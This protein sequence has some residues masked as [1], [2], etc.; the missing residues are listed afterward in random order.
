MRSSR[1]IPRASRRSVL[2]ARAESAALTCRVSNSIKACLAQTVLEPLRQG[3]G[4]QAD[5][6]DRQP[7]LAQ[8]TDQRLRL[9]PHL[10][11]AHNLTGRLQQAQAAQL[12]RHVDPN[13]GLHCRLSRWPDPNR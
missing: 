3:A 11:L 7:E 5:A 1:A 6:G 10:G 13:M 2:T 9:A 4:F 8:Q 12:Q